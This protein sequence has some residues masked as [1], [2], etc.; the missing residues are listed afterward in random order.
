M[1]N[2]LNSEAFERFAR[3]TAAVMNPEVERWKDAGGRVIGYFSE[4]LPEEMITA[5]GMLPVRLRAPES[6]GTEL[7]DSFFG[8]L[9]CTFPR[10][11]F[12]TALEGGY[13]FIDGLVMFNSCD[14]VRR[15]YDHWV[16]QMKTPFAEVLS[17]P[18]KAEAAQVEWFCG[19]LANLRQ[20]IESHYGVEIGDDALRD[21]IA[22]HNETRRLLR[23]LYDLRKADAPPI[24]GAEA[25]AVTVASTTMPQ[26]LYN[27][28]LRELLADLAGAAGITDFRARLMVLGSELDDP[29]Y[30][31]IIE[32]QGGLV[33]TDSLCFGSKILWNDVEEDTADPLMALAQYY[34]AD[35]PPHARMFTE[36]DRRAAY[37]RELIDEFRVDGAIFQRLTFCELWGYEQFIMEDDFKEWDVP[38]L[39]MDREYKLNATGQLRTRVQAFLETV[40]GR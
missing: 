38:S 4:A 1:A 21:A 33:V 31:Q 32:E 12:N 14:H 16:R 20:R 11:A 29:E 7:A 37:V 22:L 15:M 34:V 10:H 23:E 3:A 40:E 35:R 28:C 13:D 8:S 2:R 19:E 24:T 27:E 17:L 39:S 5:A 26:T 30:I 25:L 18:R 36:Y 6:R 9:N